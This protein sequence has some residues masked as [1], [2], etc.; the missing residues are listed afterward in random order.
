VETAAMVPTRPTVILVMAILTIL[1]GSF[2]ALM[3]LC[4]GV[5]M[6]LVH[7]INLPQLAPM[8]ELPEFLQREVPGYIAV[9]VSSYVLG[10]VLSV[11]LITAGIGLLRMKVWAWRTSVICSAATVVW[12]IVHTVYQWIYVNPVQAR[13]NEE[14][15]R[16]QP[17]GTPNFAAF[18]EN[19]TVIGTVAALVFTIGFPI[20][21]FVVMFLP[22][23]R[24]AFSRPVPGTAHPDD[25]IPKV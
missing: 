17:A 3:S 18:S 9:E 12:D 11:L 10:L 24:A 25:S 21:L 15:M 22:N 13:W 2:W 7:T 23:V 1:F 8:R 4:S 19:L 16:K 5:V 14:L 6:L 20:V